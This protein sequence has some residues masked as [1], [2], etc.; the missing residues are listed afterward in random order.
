MK[1]SNLMSQ[2]VAYPI[3]LTPYED[4]GYTVR[5]PDFGQYTQGEDIADA[6]YMARDAIG[7]M[8]NYLEDESSDIPAPFSSSP[9]AKWQ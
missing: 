6:L 9:T 7:M 2:R 3:F 8:G 1:G 4:G 5:I